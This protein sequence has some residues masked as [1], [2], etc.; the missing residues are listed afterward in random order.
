MERIAG[1][2]RIETAVAASRFAFPDGA[3]AV[4]VASARAFPDA[5]AA[6]PLATALGGPIL[7]V[8]DRTSQAVRDEIARLGAG[9]AVVVGGVAA[10]PALVQAELRVLVAQVRRIA[11]ESRTDTAALI[12]RAVAATIAGRGDRAPAAEAVVA[13]SREFAD[14][15]TVGPLAGAHGLPVVLSPPADLDRDAADA[16]VDLGVDRTLVVGGVEALSSAVEARLP[17][18]TRVSGPDRYATSVAV[19]S[20]TKARGATLAT[21]FV[22]TGRDFPD[23][24]AAGPVAAAA[25]GVV[26]LVDGQRAGAAEVSYAWLTDHAEE[27]ERIVV[28]GGPAAVSEEVVARLAGAVAPGRHATG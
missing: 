14:A 11:G 20:L 28:F 26:L 15:L 10:V 4:V 18:P 19:A 2:G 25:R 12:A 21:V 1:P 6:V 13:S 7:L 16:L 27:I 17:G 23:A 9:E 8:G 22:A 5:L 24:L 3:P